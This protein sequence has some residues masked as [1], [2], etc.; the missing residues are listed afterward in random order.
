V[1]PGIG[2]LN[3]GCTSTPQGSERALVRWQPAFFD[4]FLTLSILQ[5]SQD[6]EPTINGNVADSSGAVVLNIGVRRVEQRNQ[7]WDC[8]S[9]DQLL[10]VLVCSRVSFE[11]FHETKT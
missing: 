4:Y 3:S 6:S 1:Q 7:D 5:T 11:L 8:A 2:L 9:V 10:P